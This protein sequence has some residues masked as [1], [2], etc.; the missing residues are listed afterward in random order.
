MTECG[1]EKNKAAC[2]C[3]YEPCAKK[4]LCCDC[5]RSHL[6]AGEFPA[7]V[8]PP[9]VEKRFDRSIDCFIETYRQR[10]RWW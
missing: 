10:G 1:K 5:L 9:D 7:C 4:G 6:R 8:F 2:N 3:T